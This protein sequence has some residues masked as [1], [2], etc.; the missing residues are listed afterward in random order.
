MAYMV[1][2]LP[3]LST[4][5]SS[6]GAGAVSNAIGN[7]D[8]AASITVYLTSSGIQGTAGTVVQVSQFDPA[9]PAQSGVSQTT[10]WYTAGAVATSN[11]AIALTNVSFRGLRLN[12]TASS[13]FAGEVIAFV[14]KQIQV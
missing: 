2:D 6:G 14:S 12:F 13:S 5:T 4:V 11:G 1:R 8:D 9:F 3:K 10:Q 7:L